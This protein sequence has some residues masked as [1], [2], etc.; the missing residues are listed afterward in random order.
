MG[1]VSGPFR[2]VEW[3]RGRGGVGER[4]VCK[5]K[6]YHY[7]FK[8]SRISRNWTFPRRPVW[9]R[10]RNDPFFPN[11]ATRVVQEGVL[12]IYEAFFPGFP[13]AGMGAV[14]CL[15][16]SLYH[17]FQNHSIFKVRKPL[18]HVTVIAEDSREFLRRV[19]S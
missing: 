2:G 9:Q 12:W 6:E 10:L 11:A 8:F 1:S 15:G 16:L 5:G 17:S 4:G 18:N 14:V 13:P 7:M 19:L 3:G